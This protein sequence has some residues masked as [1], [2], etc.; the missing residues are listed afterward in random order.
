MATLVGRLQVP[1]D[2]SITHRALIFSALAQGSCTISGISPAADC[3]ST[4]ACL[5]KVGLEVREVSDRELVVLS[6]GI[7]KLK[8]PSEVLDCGNSGTTMRVLAGLLSGQE[9]ET[10]FDGDD[11]LRSRPMR[12]VLNPLEEMG[13]EAEFQ[14]QDGY[15]PFT[16]TGGNLRGIS[17]SSRIAS[18]QV[19]TAL[20]LAGLQAKG[21]TQI[22][23]PGNVRDHTMRMF[24]CIGVP[25]EQTDRYLTVHRLPSPLQPYA[26][27]VPGDMSSAAF[28]MVA[29]ASLPGSN[30]TLTNVGVNPGRRLI[31]DV[32][33]RMGAQITEEDERVVCEEP[34]ADIHVRFKEQLHGATISGDEV[35]AGIDELPA[36]A[37]AGAV[38]SGTLSVRGA[39][40]L[41]VKES[42]RITAISK[43]ITAAGGIVREFDDGFDITGRPALPGGSPWQ[44]FGDHR[45]AMTGMVA[46][47]ICQRPLS[48]DDTTCAAVSYPEFEKDLSRL[49]I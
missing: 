9:F 35:S 8:A 38:C 29:A 20:L 11:S 44:T 28:F 17:F 4:A 21:K 5:Q 12:R 32:L 42:D 47:L 45:L 31:I 18:A 23:I 33:R 24:R 6:P 1:G 46:S 14:T 2:K 13:A 43:N 34:V 41:R 26:I 37:L 22:E 39:G 16:L 49:L 48:I 36:L 40:E 27:E 10:T 7:D 19:Q 30:I 25:F 3:R 15:A